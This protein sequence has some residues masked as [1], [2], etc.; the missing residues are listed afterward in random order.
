MSSL[1][2]PFNVISKPVNFSFLNTCHISQRCRNSE[3]SRFLACDFQDRRKFRTHCTAWIHPVVPTSSSKSSG[4]FLLGIRPYAAI[5]EVQ[6]K[7]LV[8]LK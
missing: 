1:I 5:P 4:N 8:L 7:I 2:I 6:E 3:I